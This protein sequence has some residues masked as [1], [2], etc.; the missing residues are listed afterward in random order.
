MKSFLNIRWWY[1]KT[2]RRLER[3]ASAKLHSIQ[4][5]ASSSM[6]STVVSFDDADEGLQEEEEKEEELACDSGFRRL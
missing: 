4:I 6:T 1:R 5:R 3:P 2:F